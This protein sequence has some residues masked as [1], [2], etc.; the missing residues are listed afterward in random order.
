MNGWNDGVYDEIHPPP[1]VEE[2]RCNAS[3]DVG[4][5]DS[6]SVVLEW[7]EPD[8]I[9]T[10][11]EPTFAI[12]KLF[13]TGGG[14]IIGGRPDLGK[15]GFACSTAV[16][17]ATGRGDVLG[18]AED[19]APG[20]VGILAME[21]DKLIIW[22][23]L[24]A[25]ARRFGIQPGSL[26]GRIAVA[27]SGGMETVE[28][29]AS[30]C[31]LVL[32]DPLAFLLNAVSDDDDRENSNGAMARVIGQCKDLATKYKTAIGIFHHE[33]KAGESVGPGPDDYDAIRGAGSLV[34]SARSVLLVRAHAKQ[35]AQAGIPEDDAEHLIRV[36]HVKS[37][38]TAKAETLVFRRTPQ[39]WRDAEAKPVLMLDPFKMPAEADLQARLDDDALTA[40]TALQEAPR[41][42]RRTAPNT[43][44]WAGHLIAAALGM[45]T[46]QKPERERLNA[47]L[48]HL[49]QAGKISEE[50]WKDDQRK[51][52][53]SWTVQ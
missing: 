13:P 46:V 18:M 3:A 36:V 22:P 31:E 1:P 28:A 16:A 34:G 6:A 9:E 15:T 40:F 52:R 37:N 5:E 14:T 51:W 39:A 45:E 20:K 26:R 38:W 2:D 32:I 11:P 8:E 4:G 41:E 21:D 12:A 44:G 48:R 23:R 29:L 17:K 19:P 27:Y 33:R 43:H 10:L 49:D 30:Q 50:D 42:K 7:Y 25:V 53:R 35:A 24:A 47:I